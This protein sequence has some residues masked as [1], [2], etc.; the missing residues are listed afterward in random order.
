ML[1]HFARR[2]IV[3]PIT[4]LSMT[5]LEST[6]ESD[7][8]SN[9]WTMQRVSFCSTVTLPQQGMYGD[10]QCEHVCRTMGLMQT[11]MMARNV[12]QVFPAMLMKVEIG[13]AIPKALLRT[14]SVL[15]QHA[16]EA[17]IKELTKHAMS[18]RISDSKKFDNAK[19]KCV[20]IS[21]FI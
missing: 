14:M 12:T 9:V 20:I 17:M 18:S 15:P 1:T 8:S 13:M 10:G 16:Y 6:F 2:T 11:R 7:T 19:F 3:S 5:L 21:L 4:F